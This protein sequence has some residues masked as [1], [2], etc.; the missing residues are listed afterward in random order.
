MARV[1]AITLNP[2]LDCSIA[3]DR[4][5][6]GTVHRVS[7]AMTTPAGK[8]HNVARVL[9]A[10]R[11]DVTVAGF[12]GADNA[13]VFET[14]FAQWGVNDACVRIA[15]ETRTNIKLAEAAGRVTDFNAVG[16]TVAPD[17]WNRL[18]AGLDRLAA[19][20][21]DAVVIAGSLPPGV[22]ARR[23]HELIE[24]LR[25]THGPVW[26]D[27]SGEALA[28]A[29]QAVPAAIKPNDHE[30]AEWAGRP[31]A[32]EHALTA[33]AQ[34]IRQAGVP[35]VVVSRGAAGVLWFGT[36]SAL[37]AEAP[38]VSVVSTVCAGDT[39]V[40]GL[41]HGRLSGWTDRDTLAFATALAADAVTRIGVGRSDTPTFESLKAAVAIRALVDPAPALSRG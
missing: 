32:D 16:P 23:I 36:E 34:A 41:L 21:F 27:V 17:D 35:D 24:C 11:H 39:L 8:G 19:T 4:L 29:V 12:L 38:A 28:A 22:D 1:L 6:P 3:L 7:A 18:M 40:A 15:G 25:N 10:H 37:A 20:R 13:A 5:V 31:L 26:I 30:L 9:A 14:A 2:A 33:A